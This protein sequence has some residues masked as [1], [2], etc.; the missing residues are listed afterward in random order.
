MPSI[1][2]DLRVRANDRLITF[3]ANAADLRFY[4][5]GREYAFEIGVLEVFNESDAKRV[6]VFAAE[7]PGYEIQESADQRP[8]KNEAAVAGATDAPS[9]PDPVKSQ[10]AASEPAAGATVAPAAVS[11]PSMNVH[12]MRVDDLRS[13]ALARELDPAGLN[14]AEI[15][16][17]L[18]ANPGTGI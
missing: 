10:N 3:T 11:E 8:A 9:A 2:P 14:R 12:R 17:L 18:I 15:I 7:N 6:R 16:E 4:S 13:L 1:H 5:G